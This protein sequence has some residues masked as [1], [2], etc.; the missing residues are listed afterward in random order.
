M[1]MPRSCSAKEGDLV[2]VLNGAETPFV[3]RDV[4]RGELIYDEDSKI[5][6]ELV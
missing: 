1:K 4:M 2:V 3:L 5:G 6:F